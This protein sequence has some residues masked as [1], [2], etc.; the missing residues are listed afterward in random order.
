MATEIRSRVFYPSLAL[1]M[2]AT[3]YWGF[4]YTYFAPVAASAYADVSPAVHV[5]GWTFFLWFLLFPLQAL[6]MATGRRRAHFV[7][8]GV[9]LAL[10]AAMTFTG[11]LVAS[12]RIRQGLTATAPDELT[13]FWKN[14]GLL[15]SYSLVLFVGF[16]SAAIAQRKQ[17]EVHKR[18]MI[19]A[20]ASA[21]PAAVF[22][23]IVAMFGYYWL[24]PPAWVMPAAFF[25]PN[26]FIVAGMVHDLAVRHSIQ[27]V[28]LIGLPIVIAVEALG[29]VLAG[30]PA[31][32]TISRCIASFSD[33][34]G[35][36]Y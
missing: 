28:Y 35:R 32:E 26:L 19:I 22:R 21:I 25:L 17:P 3:V 2:S 1:A 6:L 29:L 9:S 7:L 18:L 13:T 20:S 34:F 23:I 16:Y 10:A 36:L 4:Y 11:L 14:F 33:V 24:A 5:H 15:I 30:T 12:V 27:R 31:G 8:G